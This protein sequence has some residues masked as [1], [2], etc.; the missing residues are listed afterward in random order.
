[1]HSA[2]R[3]FFLP[4]LIA[5][6]AAFSAG[7]AAAQLFSLPDDDPKARA[8]LLPGY[9]AEGGRVAA[10]RIS[11]DPGWKTY[12]RRPGE[13]GI[14]PVF[15]WSGSENLAEVKIAWPAPEAFDSYG[16]LTLGYHD[17]MLLPLTITAADPAAPVKL[18]LGLTYGVCEDICIP[19]RA[20]LSLTIAPGAPDEGAAAIRAALAAQPKKAP[21]GLI[22]SAIC[23]I[24]GGENGHDFTARF[25]LGGTP[26]RAPFIVAEGPEGV[27]FSALETE[28]GE[29][30]LIATGEMRIAA[31]A[32]ADRSA[33]LFTFLDPQGGP[34]IE[35]Q[36]CGA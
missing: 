21:E 7:G 12:W 27:S 17:E 31:G 15:D 5:S 33:L 19:A 1:M 10:L 18:S 9:A 6:F 29:N 3:R 36:G 16:L 22:I 28:I 23:E 11:L 25:S 4:G 30:A 32:W 14:S 8:E 20:D 35:V 2:L 13:A 24:G 26:G 34:A